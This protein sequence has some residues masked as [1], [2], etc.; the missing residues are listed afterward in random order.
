MQ[1]VSQ[2]SEV[3]QILPPK[4]V[5]VPDRKRLCKDHNDFLR[6]LDR[7][8]PVTSAG[9]SEA[10]GGHGHN[11]EKSSFLKDFEAL[12]EALHCDPSCSGS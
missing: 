6:K 11:P 9:H 1:C 7:V 8:V 2:V 5:L 4:L 10:C 3:S 12:P